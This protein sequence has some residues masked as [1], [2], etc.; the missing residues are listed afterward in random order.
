MNS[1]KK[2]L[3]KISII[4]RLLISTSSAFANAGFTKVNQIKIP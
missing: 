4:R 3:Y 1:M 2:E